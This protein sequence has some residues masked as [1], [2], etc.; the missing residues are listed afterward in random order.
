MLIVEQNANHALRLAHRGYVMVNGLITFKEPALSCCSAR[1]S[2]PPIWKA[3]GAGN[4]AA[5]SPRVVPAN[6]GTSLC[7]TGDSA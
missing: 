4:A 2:V 1:K 3:A 6:A 5:P 7:C